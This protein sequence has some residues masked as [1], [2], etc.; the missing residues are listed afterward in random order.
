MI[1]QKNYYLLHHGVN[2]NNLTNHSFFFFDKKMSCPLPTDCLNEIFEN[3]DDDKITLHSCLLVSR[4]WCKISV[5]ILWRDI[6]GFKYDI[7]N[8]DPRSRKSRITGITP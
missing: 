3:L 5:R 7:Y 2:L 8:S 4:L 6:W 1:D